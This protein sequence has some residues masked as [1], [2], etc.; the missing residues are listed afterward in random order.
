M[1]KV[2]LSCLFIPSFL[3]GQLDE[4]YEYTREFIWGVNKNTRGGLIG[5]LVLKWSRS[6]GNDLFRTFGFEMSSIKHPKEVKVTVSTGQTFVLGKSHYLYALRFQTG[7][8]KLLFRKDT[9]QGVQINVGVMG[10]PT[11]GI[12]APYYVLTSDGTYSRYQI[13]TN[14]VGPGKFLQGLGQ[15]SLVLGTNIKSS[16]SFEFGTYKNNVAG[17]ELGVMLEAYTRQIELLLAQEKESFF[18][19]AFIMLYWG[20]RK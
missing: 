1:K 8:D 7:L 15:S 13:S 20:R 14:A 11:L 3:F 16:L 4:N 19:T 18:P 9:Q 2:L 10:G 5:S 6:R 12:H 17:M